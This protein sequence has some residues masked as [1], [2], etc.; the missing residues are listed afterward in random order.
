[1]LLKIFIITIILVSIAVLGL[2]FRI[3]L[4]KDG[5]FPD[6]HVGH[7][8]QMRKLGISCSKDESCL[9][10]GLE[11]KK[12]KKPTTTP[13]KMLRRHQNIHKPSASDDFTL[14]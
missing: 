10:R 12:K 14:A 2:A 6:T 13:G 11:E 5:K 1:M 4:I 8:P 3:L 7:N 9:C